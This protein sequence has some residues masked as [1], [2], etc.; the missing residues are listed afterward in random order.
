[1][2]FQHLLVDVD[3]GDLDRAL[4]EP[5][6]KVL[7]PLWVTAKAMEEWTGSNPQVPA[8]TPCCLIVSELIFPFLPKVVDT[9]T[10]DLETIVAAKLC[11]STIVCATFI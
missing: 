3:A 6:R 4:E 8:G 1:V 10:I 2:P 7:T 11:L 9:Q 5:L